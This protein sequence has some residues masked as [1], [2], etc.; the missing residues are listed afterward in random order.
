MNILKSI[1]SIGKILY[2]KDKS[3]VLI[4]TIGSFLTMLFSVLQ[5]YIVKYIVDSLQNQT[6]DISLQFFLLLGGILYL[7][8]IIGT[9]TA[10]AMSRISE[11]GLYEEERMILEKTASL[12][13]A[14]IESPE[15]K[16]MRETASHVSFDNTFVRG[17][18][19][20]NGIIQLFIL[21]YIVTFRGH[22]LLAI[23]A[24]L[25][26]FVQ[27]QA[28]RKAALGMEQV[29]QMQSPFRKYA[30][31]IVELLT[32][33][34]SV[35]EIRIFGISSFLKN[36][37]ENIL[38]KNRKE[39]LKVSIKGELIKLT[40][41][42]IVAILSGLS[43]AILVILLALTGESAGQFALLFQMTALLFTKMP[44]LAQ[45]HA[46]M[47]SNVSRYNGFLKFIELENE[48][49]YAC[50]STVANTNVEDTKPALSIETNNLCFKYP[51]NSQYTLDNISLHIKAGEKLAIV[52]ENGS[53][54][55]TLVKLLLGLYQATSGEVKWMKNGRNISRNEMLKGIRLVFQ[56]YAKLHRT[57]RENIAIG[58]ID[59]INDDK[60]IDIALIKAKG[61]D[62]KVKKDIQIGPEFDGMELSGGQWQKI[63]TSRA[64]L[65]EGDCLVF[66]EPTAAL[67]A[68]TELEVFTSF[69]DLVENQTAIFITHRL[70]AA[71]LVDTILV[72][73]DGYLI[74]KGSHQDLVKLNGEYARLYK[75][76]SSW[77]K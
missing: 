17:I 30:T 5:L 18:S 46:F 15:I 37:W 26:F 13:L 29:F 12:S 28:H 27:M 8:I 74:E 70:A 62:F 73:K 20:I 76:Q 42:L 19:Y 38:R 3:S 71:R 54:K 56:D 59:Q 39:L 60:E 22:W 43:A 6:I 66:D 41:D 32:N 44:E 9:P 48:D 47:Q 14:A 36:K 69:L 21:I 68:K 35:L 57:V 49:K 75:L 55:T 77:Y 11:I 67:D 34:E 64:Y 50:S 7:Q 25:S 61:E 72:M 65:K 45:L 4:V 63:A 52:G 16:T 10:L 2:K 31:Y 40:P 1:Y 58:N 33:R 51:D 23:I 53:G 24:F